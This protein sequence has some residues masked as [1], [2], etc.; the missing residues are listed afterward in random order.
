LSS[1]TRNFAWQ[2]VQMT[3]MRPRSGPEITPLLA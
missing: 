2:R 3:I 1:A